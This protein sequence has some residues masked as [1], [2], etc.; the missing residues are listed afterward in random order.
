MN[1]PLDVTLTVA[2]MYAEALMEA[3][4]NLTEGLDGGAD[5][6]LASYLINEELSNQHE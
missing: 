1:L 2:E 6:A 4:R 5:V 3:C